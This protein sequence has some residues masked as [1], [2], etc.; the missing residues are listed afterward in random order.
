MFGSL[1]SL[2]GGG[3]L[4]A[5]TSASTDGGTLSSSDVFNGGGVSFGTNK[6]T[7]KNVMYAG[8]A[9]VTLITMVWIA[10]RGKAKSK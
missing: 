9:A 1:T 4:S 6:Q 2:T 8:I 5:S 10:K 3:G 7:D